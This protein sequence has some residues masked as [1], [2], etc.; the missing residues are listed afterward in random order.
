M[1]SFRVTVSHPTASVSDAKTSYVEVLHNILQNE[2]G[3]PFSNQTCRCL[4]DALT[5]SHIF[6]VNILFSSP[7]WEPYGSNAK[8]LPCN[9]TIFLDDSLI[10]FI[11]QFV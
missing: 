9:L 8:L 7:I 10:D 5:N 11:L 3:F 6:G 4:E 2:W 1:P